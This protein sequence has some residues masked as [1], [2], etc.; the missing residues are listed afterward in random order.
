MVRGTEPVATITARPSTICVSP[1]APSTAIRPG[2]SRRPTPFTTATLRFFSSPDSPFTRPATTAFLRASAASQSKL[3]SPTTTPKSPA[4]RTVV[5]TSAACSQLLA[6]M[7]P[8]NKQVPPTSS[9]STRA[10][11]RPKLCA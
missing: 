2:P 11:S 3:A 10:T 4:L 8:R 7:Q 1:S 6:G 9:F 5:I